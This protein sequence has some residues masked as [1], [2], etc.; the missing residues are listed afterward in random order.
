VSATDVPAITNAIPTSTIEPTP[1]M[2]TE[3]RSLASSGAMLLRR[4]NDQEINRDNPLMNVLLHYQVGDQVDMEVYRMSVAKTMTFTRT[5]VP[6][7]DN[8]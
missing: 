3:R 1:L 4:L 2:M 6:I 7:P 8:T 5:L